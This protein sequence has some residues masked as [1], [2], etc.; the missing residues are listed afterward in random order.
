MTAILAREGGSRWCEFAAAPPTAAETFLHLY[1]QTQFLLVHR[2]VDAVVRAIVDESRWG[3]EGPEFA[4]FV[5]ASPASTVAA[6]ASYWATHTVRQ[7]E[8]EDANPASCLRVRIEDLAADTPQARSDIGE[9]L[10]LD[11]GAPAPRLADDGGPADAGSSAAGLPVGQLPAS[12]LA[13]VDH[14]HARLGYPPVAAA[15]TR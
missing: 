11:A 5:A 14:L 8:F 4:P 6:L 12:L 15:G 13:Q 10:S 7:L 1:P 3:L 9:F 2:R